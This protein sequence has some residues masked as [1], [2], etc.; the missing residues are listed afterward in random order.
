MISQLQGNRVWVQIGLLHEIGLL[1]LSD[2]MIDKCDRN[3]QR[4]KTVVVSIDD[5][6]QLLL[7]I[8]GQLSFEVA[9]NMLQD[10]RVLFYRGFELKS[11]G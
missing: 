6:E 10:I 5:L 9:H 3:N 2:I 4:H 11:F 8:C 7:F 1:V